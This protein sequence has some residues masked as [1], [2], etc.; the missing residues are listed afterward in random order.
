MVNGEIGPDDREIAESMWDAYRF[1]F[2]PEDLWGTL[3]TRF[4]TQR[5]V[6][7]DDEAFYYDV[8]GISR[9]ARNREQFLDHLEKRRKERIHQIN[10]AFT[11]MEHHFLRDRG[12]FGHDP[13]N[14]K[15]NKFFRLCSTGSLDALVLFIASFLPDEELEKYR[16]HPNRDHRGEAEDRYPR[17]AF[18]TP[19][20]PLPRFE[21]ESWDV[22]DIIPPPSEEEAAARQRWYREM[23][24]T[25]PHER[26]PPG[27]P[28]PP[29]SPVT[30]PSTPVSPSILSPESSPKCSP[31]CDHKTA[32]EASGS[33]KTG[34]PC[35]NLANS[36][37]L[38]RKRNMRSEYEQPTVQEEQPSE[39][40]GCYEE[41][42]AKRACPTDGGVGPKPSLEDTRV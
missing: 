2:E 33:I 25:P 15:S 22:A 29:Q 8:L 4:N 11:S 18:Q 35:P 5:T 42:I 31:V 1:G 41:P 14:R 26:V 38:K 40:E 27:T 34:A 30:I 39:Q 36:A 10:A 3:F 37:G 6:I 17:G 20:P 21:P 7:Q 32:L 19:P 9:V 23:F 16:L 13:M 24:G 28:T 12:L